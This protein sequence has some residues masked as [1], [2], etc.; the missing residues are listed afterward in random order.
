MLSGEVE[1]ELVVSGEGA[2]MSGEKS[3]GADIMMLVCVMVGRCWG[4]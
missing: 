2:G 1:A 3:S 4:I